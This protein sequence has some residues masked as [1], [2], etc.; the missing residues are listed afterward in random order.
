MCNIDFIVN[1]GCSID[2]EDI[3]VLS[4]LI[5]YIEENVIVFLNIIA[6]SF[7]FLQDFELISKIEKEYGIYL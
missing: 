7:H 5:N 6:P 2:F 4:S 3:T 1:F